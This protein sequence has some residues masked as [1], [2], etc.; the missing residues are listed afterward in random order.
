MLRH[1]LILTLSIYNSKPFQEVY[2]E[3]YYLHFP[4]IIMLTRMNLLN[5]K[6]T[7]LQLKM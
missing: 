4:R 2:D 3:Y 1:F 6:A 5:K 7:Q